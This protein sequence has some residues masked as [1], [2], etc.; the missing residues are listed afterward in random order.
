MA[1]RMQWWACIYLFLLNMSSLSNLSTLFFN[2]KEL[3]NPPPL[4]TTLF[5]TGFDK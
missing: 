3:N 2:L 5:V 1:Y 4:R